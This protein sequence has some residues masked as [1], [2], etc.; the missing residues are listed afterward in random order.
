MEYKIWFADLSSP[1]LFVQ[2]K[3][4]Y[5]RCLI[6]GP[7]VFVSIEQSIWDEWK[8]NDFAHPIV[9]RQHLSNQDFLFKE[10]VV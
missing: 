10:F 3:T 4:S 7:N 2:G 6:I 1:E 9:V 5:Q 8:T